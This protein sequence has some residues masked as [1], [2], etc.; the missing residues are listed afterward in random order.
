[1]RNWLGNLVD[2]AHWWTCCW[3]RTNNFKKA[4]E[5][6]ERQRRWRR[7]GYQREGTFNLFELSIICCLND[8]LLSNTIFQSLSSRRKLIHIIK[9]GLHFGIE[10]WILCFQ[11]WIK[12]K[13]RVH[14]RNHR[15]LRL[16]RDRERSKNPNV[17]SLRWRTYDKVS[18]KGDTNVS[19]SLHYFELVVF[20]NF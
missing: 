11:S 17:S 18:S 8:W 5:A 9:F 16:Y 6:R 14:P 7:C 4:D 15:K 1:M 12:L 19:W 20:M 3:R 10:L 2:F 13:L